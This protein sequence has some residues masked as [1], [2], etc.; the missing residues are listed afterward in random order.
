MTIAT[1]CP[2]IRRSVSVPRPRYSNLGRTCF[3]LSRKP[4]GY[5]TSASGTSDQ[6]DRFVLVNAI[7]A[8]MAPMTARAALVMTHGLRKLSPLRTRDVIVST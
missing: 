5:R 4:I 6:R 3:E 2:D 7:P 8:K 1:C